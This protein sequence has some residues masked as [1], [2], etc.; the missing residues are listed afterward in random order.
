MERLAAQ[1]V[2]LGRDAASAGRGP[3]HGGGLRT[4][5]LFGGRGFRTSSLPN[6]CGWSLTGTC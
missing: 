3:L 1:L 4:L 2:I 6:I 5:D